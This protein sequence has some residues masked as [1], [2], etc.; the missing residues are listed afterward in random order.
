MSIRNAKT[1]FERHQFRW[2]DLSLNYFVADIFAQ[3]N[4]EKQIEKSI[5]SMI[6]FDDVWQ[7]VHIIINISVINHDEIFQ[8]LLNALTKSKNCSLICTLNFFQFIHIFFFQ[9]CTV[10]Y[11]FEKISN[12][13]DV[14][15]CFR[16]GL[17]KICW[18]SFRNKRS[19]KVKNN[20][21]CITVCFFFFG[22]EP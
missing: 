6:K 22:G 12:I 7:N 3:K 14:C 5:E 18:I 17:C 9:I 21:V 15:D 10:C 4:F 1:H 8:K 19:K 20:I 2:I 13:D 11:A 16:L